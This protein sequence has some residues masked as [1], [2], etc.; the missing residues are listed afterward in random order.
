MCPH[1]TS[2]CRQRNPVFQYRVRS[3]KFKKIKNKKINSPNTPPPPHPTH[4][5]S[6]HTGEMIQQQFL[7]VTSS[8]KYKK[9]TPCLQSRVGIILICQKIK[10][11]PNSRTKS[12]VFLLPVI[13]Q[14]Y[15]HSLNATCYFTSSEQYLEIP[16]LPPESTIH[17]SV[18][19]VDMSCAQFSFSCTWSEGPIRSV[20][21]I[22]NMINVAHAAIKTVYKKEVNWCCPIANNELQCL[23][24]S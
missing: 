23:S 6:H 12:S 17:T 14:V 16:F 19:S 9:C 24:R 4:K 3:V 10:L 18:L 22:Y 21:W 13:K 1:V 11:V 20:Y 8:H 15:N 2:V 7:L 5:W